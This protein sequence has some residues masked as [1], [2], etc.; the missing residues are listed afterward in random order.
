MTSRDST[1]AGQ[2][3]QQLR[4][5]FLLQ[6]AIVCMVVV[7]AVLGVQALSGRAAYPGVSLVAITLLAIAKPRGAWGVV[8]WIGAAALASVATVRAAGWVVW[9]SLLL[10]AA[11]SP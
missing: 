1:V 11:P 6:V 3:Q 5:I 4:E 10:A 7:F 8:L 2:Q 9:P